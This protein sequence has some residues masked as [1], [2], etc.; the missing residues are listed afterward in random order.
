MDLIEVDGSRGEGGGQILRTAAAFAAILRRPVRV[1]KVRAGR[2]PSGLRRQHASAL[3]VFS[4]LF[5][6]DLQGAHEG[7]STVTFAPGAPKGGSISIDMGTAASSTLLLQAVVPAAALSG[8]RLSLELVGGTDVPWSPTFDYFQ[9]VASRGYASVGINVKVSSPRRGYYPRGGGVVN[10]VIEPCASP[11]P[12]ELS[13]ERRVLGANL[14]SRCAGLPARVAERQLESASS[15]VTS[16]GFAVAS[17]RTSVEESSSPGTS[18][19]VYSTEEGAMLGGDAI[20][21]RG[22]PAEEVGAEAAAR[23]VGA[24]SSGAAI[25]SNLAD[26]V[27]PLLSL[28][29]APSRVR[30]PEVTAH[31][32]TGLALAAQF[33]SCRWSVERGQRSAVVSVDPTLTQNEGRR[34]NV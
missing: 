22:K 1:T 21:S 12:L 19:L 14:V 5:G 11:R 4:Q 26:M 6:G 8:V 32:E 3:R 17:A 33:T 29:D 25:D 10:A 18:I 34:H 9:Q 15:R 24:A 2:E 20:G 7:S 16:A 13:T 28:A 27:I 23:F 31:L 30:V